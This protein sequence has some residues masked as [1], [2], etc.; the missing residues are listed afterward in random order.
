MLGPLGVVVLAFVMFPG[1]TPRPE[2][3]PRDRLFIVLR[4]WGRVLKTAPKESRAV[5]LGHHRGSPTSRAL[6]KGQ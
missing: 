3:R 6:T 1:W 4:T 2:H 5:L